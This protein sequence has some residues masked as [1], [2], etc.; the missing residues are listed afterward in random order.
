MKKLFLIASVATAFAAVTAEPAFAHHV[1]FGVSGAHGREGFNDWFFGN[2]GANVYSGLSGHDQIFGTSDPTQADAGDRLCG[3]GWD[4][5]VLG[6]GGNDF[7]SG[8]GGTD[9]VLGHGGIDRLLGGSGNDSMDG[10]S[11]DDQ[12]EGGYGDD[13]LDG[14]SGWD[15]C[16]G[17]PGTDKFISCEF[18]G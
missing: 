4:D 11:G 1:C 16:Y 13:T 12:L 15:R 9:A 18:I 14:N 10:G 17:G 8:G 7:L 3:N 5:D 6:Y 2:S